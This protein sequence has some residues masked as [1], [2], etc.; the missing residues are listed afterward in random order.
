MCMYIYI[1]IY[2]YTCQMT[3]Q[4]RLDPLPFFVDSCCL[5]CLHLLLSQ[6]EVHP[7]PT[8]KASVDFQRM[9]SQ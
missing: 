7:D 8:S 1:Y 4:K 2:I 9:R 3:S 5:H 6:A